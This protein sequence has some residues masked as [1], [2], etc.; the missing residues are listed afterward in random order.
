MLAEEYYES[1][2]KNG[3]TALDLGDPL[4]QM[5]VERD[6]HLSRIRE[7]EIRKFPLLEIR[8]HHDGQMVEFFISDSDAFDLLV[9]EESILKRMVTQIDGR[10]NR[11]IPIVEKAC[12]NSNCSVPTY[13]G[14]VNQRSRL[15][16]ENVLMKDRLKERLVT[17]LQRRDATLQ[18]AEKDIKYQ[19]MKTDIEKRIPINEEKIT[20][21]FDS[22]KRIE[23][24]IAE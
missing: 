18:S 15:L 16:R 8:K 23:E 17:L 4:F 7:L 24:V 6:D 14:L 3:S 11:I 19:K 2:I 5:F 20:K 12:E 10:L 21:L 22:I 13:T 1:V 9:K